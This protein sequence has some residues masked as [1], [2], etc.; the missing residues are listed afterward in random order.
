M[1]ISILTLYNYDPTIFA[2][3]VLP[4]GLDRAT[5]ISTIVTQN[6]ELE[7]LYS[8]P[9]ILKQLIAAWSASSQ[10]SWNKLAATL[11]FDY[12]PIWN[13]DGTIT[14]VETV[15]G[16]GTDVGQVAGFDSDSFQNRSK[17]TGESTSER[18]YTRVEQGNIGLTSTQ[19]LIT[20]ERAVSKFNIYDEISA[21]FKNRFCLMVY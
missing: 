17:A 21:D 13:K 10:Y 11:N 15:E 6:A 19:Q 14:E 18:S 3:M 16:N 20:E 9:D 7:L 1:L 12:N 5:A 2:D 8:D 4:E